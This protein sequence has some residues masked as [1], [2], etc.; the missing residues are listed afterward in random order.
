MVPIT[1]IVQERMELTV[2]KPRPLRTLS[3]VAARLPPFR[4]R[5]HAICRRS[6]CGNICTSWST[7]TAVTAGARRPPVGCAG[8]GPG[9]RY[10]RIAKYET[11][12]K[13]TICGMFSVCSAM[14]WRGRLPG[15]FRRSKRGRY[16]FGGWYEWC[17]GFDDRLIGT[18]QSRVACERNSSGFSVQLA[19]G[20][21]RSDVGRA[22]PRP[23]RVCRSSALYYA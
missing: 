22:F 8:P 21:G 20:S 13:T 17:A 23:V 10:H 9:L 2:S 14:M 19:T 7:C 3:V 12:R 5:S 1:S 18:T 15:R 6:N 11:R 16:V 4:V